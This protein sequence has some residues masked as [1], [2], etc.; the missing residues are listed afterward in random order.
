MVRTLRAIN[1]HTSAGGLRRAGAG[2]LIASGL[3]DLASALGPFLSW[4][5]VIASVLTLALGIMISRHEKRAVK[6]EAPARSV[7]QRCLR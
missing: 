2:G 5:V 6:T 1:E 3:T 7:K 4:F